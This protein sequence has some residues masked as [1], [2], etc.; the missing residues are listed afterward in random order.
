MYIYTYNI[1]ILLSI[2]A[3]MYTY[4]I[5]TY[6]YL[7]K[8][9]QQQQQFQDNTFCCISKDIWEGHS[10]KR[11]LLASGVGLS[12]SFGNWGWSK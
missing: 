3:A 7:Y 1:Y 4:N 12:D 9:Q 11:A 2:T 8:Q 6:I 5:Y 10:G